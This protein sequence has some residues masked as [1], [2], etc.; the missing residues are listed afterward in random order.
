MT[1]QTNGKHNLLR[2]NT[3]NPVLLQQN[4]YFESLLRAAYETGAINDDNIKR[5]Q[6]DCLHLLAEKTNKYTG[7]SASVLIEDAETIMKSNLYTVGLYLKSLA[8]PADAVDV[9]KSTPVSQLY[10]LGQRKIK[11]KLALCKHLYRNVVKNMM[12]IDY[13]YYKLTLTKEIPQFLALYTDYHIWY[14]AHELPGNVTFSYPVACQ[15][16]LTNDYLGIE[17]VQKYLE[18]LYYENVF[19]KCFTDDVIYRVLHDFHWDYNDILFNVFERVLQAAVGRVVLE[20]NVMF[21]DAYE[22][23]IC[24]IGLENANAQKYVKDAMQKI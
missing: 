14:K 21:S 9:V 4:A 20:E 8:T 5:I 2:A 1:G 3:I 15:G 22:K 12:G 6:M 24:K 13:A 7:G 16:D 18:A 19:C 17:Y 11:T 10:E 23:S